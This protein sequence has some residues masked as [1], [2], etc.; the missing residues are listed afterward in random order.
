MFTKAAVHEH[1]VIEAALLPLGSAKP[2]RHS[3]D[4]GATSSVSPLQTVSLEGAPVSLVATV[5][6][7]LIQ[8]RARLR[9]QREAAE[10]AAQAAEAAAA[11]GM[12]RNRTAGQWE[13]PP[14]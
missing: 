5:E 4:R 3:I 2:H 9:Q 10:A 6:Q 8:E 13:N 12:A 7:Y 11:L 14:C 1:C